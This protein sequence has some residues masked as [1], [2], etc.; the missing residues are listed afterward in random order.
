MKRNELFVMATSRTG[1]LTIGYLMH[2]ILFFV[3]N[4]VA[5]LDDM[6]PLAASKNT[7]TRKTP[8]SF[9]GE[10]SALVN[11]DQLIKT[12]NPTTTGQAAYNPFGDLSQPPKTN[13]FQQ[14]MQPVNDHPI[15]FFSGKN[16][17]LIEI[18]F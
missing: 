9:L 16:V 6:D 8:Q 13:L 5:L 1:H 4:L 7:N 15:V 18:D 14:Q 10:N 11:L 17:F 2:Y 12:S 3:C